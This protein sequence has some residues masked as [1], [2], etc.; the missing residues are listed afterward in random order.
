MPE[1]PGACPPA[2]TVTEILCPGVTTYPY[3]AA[4]PPPPAP[5]APDC[6]EVG[7]A[8]EPPPAPP[9]AIT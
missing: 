7:P 4:A 5:Y 1:A 9:P 3:P 2:P 8:V 6:G